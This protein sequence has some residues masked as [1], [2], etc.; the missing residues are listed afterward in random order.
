MIGGEKMAKL[1]DMTGWKMTEH[2]VPNSRI[3]VIRRAYDVIKPTP[4]NYNRVQ[5]QI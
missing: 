1:I 3:T 2:G 4:V 5:K